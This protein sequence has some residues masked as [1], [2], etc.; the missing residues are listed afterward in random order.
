MVKGED[1]NYETKKD[2]NG[3]DISMD[4]V[5]K[6]LDDCSFKLTFNEMNSL[7]KRILNLIEKRKNE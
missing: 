3:Y 1:F 6:A 2:K 4:G 7:I 5:Y